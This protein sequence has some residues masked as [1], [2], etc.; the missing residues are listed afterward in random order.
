MR[1]NV[2]SSFMCTIMED[3]SIVLGGSGLLAALGEWLRRIDV[4]PH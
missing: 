1:S 2:P 3:L 4:A